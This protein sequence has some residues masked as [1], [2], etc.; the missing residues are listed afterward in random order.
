MLAGLDEVLF[1]LEPGAELQEVEAQLLEFDSAAHP[2]LQLV[3]L[4]LFLLE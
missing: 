1:E 4:V 2:A 3:E